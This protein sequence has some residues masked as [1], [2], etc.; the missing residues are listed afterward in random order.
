MVTEKDKVRNVFCLLTINCS[1]CVGYNT[2][3]IKILHIRQG[4]SI[5]ISGSRTDRR[6]SK[7]NLL[8]T[9]DNRLDPLI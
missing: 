6:M 2:G 8:E 1:S 9:N 5:R 7:E 3:Q 4:E